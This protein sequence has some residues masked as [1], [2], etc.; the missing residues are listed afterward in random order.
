MIRLYIYSVVEIETN[1]Q[2]M[3]EL[4]SEEWRDVMDGVDRTVRDTLLGTVDGLLEARVTTVEV[5]TT[6]SQPHN[7]EFGSCHP[8][9]QQSLMA[10]QQDD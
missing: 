8:E 5:Q 2:P 7:F 4:H 9:V 1:S 3:D 10:S 6:W